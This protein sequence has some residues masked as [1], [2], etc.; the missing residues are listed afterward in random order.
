V[1]TTSSQR[2][3]SL[4]P[5]LLKKVN[6]PEQFHVFVGQHCWD[7]AADVLMDEQEVRNGPHCQC[8]WSTT[9]T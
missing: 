5:P 3:N 9:T 4:K 1:K 2:E 6:K 8:H 7:V